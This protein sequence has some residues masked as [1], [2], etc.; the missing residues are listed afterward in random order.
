MTLLADARA[1]AETPNLD[2]Q[3]YCVY[4]PEIVADHSPG[5]PWLSMPQIVA[6]LEAAERLVEHDPAFV[7]A[8]DRPA[9]DA[10]KAALRGDG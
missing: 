9:Y 2:D 7:Y 4:C 5:C 10:L 6:A 1:I 8:D 3:G